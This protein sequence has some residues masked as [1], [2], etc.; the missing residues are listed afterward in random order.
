MGHLKL[1]IKGMHCRS[2]EMLLEEKI[3]EVPHVSSVN[4]SYSQGLANIEYSANQPSHKDLERAV[5][6][7]GYEVGTREPAKWLSDKWTDYKQLIVA[8]ITLWVLY[9]I[10]RMLGILDISLNTGSVTYP[11]ALVIGL[12]AGISTCMAIVGGLILGIS[13]RHAEVH[14]E[15]TSWQKFRPHL[16]FNIG[17]ISG[18]AV[19]GGLLGAMGSVLKISGTVQALL[20]LA[21][22]AV[23]IVLGLKLT[24][25]S[26]RLKESSITLPASLAKLLGINRHQKE[27]SHKSAMLT[28]ALTFFLPC[29]FTQAMQLAAIGSGNFVSGALIMG[30]FAIGTAPALLSIGGLTSVIK[31]AVAQ[32]FY[33][34]V[35]LAVFL[36][37]IYNANNALALVGF[38]GGSFNAPAVTN[39]TEVV[40]GV[41]IVRMTQKSAGYYPNSFTVKKGVPV[42]WVV[43]S[44]APYSCAASINM[45]SM[46]INQALQ[47]GE[48]VI[49]FTPT[50]SGRL[51]FSC[52]MGMY[53]GS[54]NVIDQTGSAGVINTA[55]AA[56]QPVATRGGSCGAG[57]GGCGGCGGGGARQRVVAPAVDTNA[58]DST[59]VQKIVS[60]DNRSLTPND[61]TVKVGQPV[62]WTITADA[63][64]A[65][66]MASFNNYDLGISA[67]ETYPDPTIIKFTPKSPGDYDITCPM[68]M[69]RATIH[70]K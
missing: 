57:G 15:A 41:Q 67:D 18:Y 54:F 30:L 43:T 35:G 62:E 63:P 68:G 69:Y 29:G 5:Q 31:G 25:I 40:D 26:P 38:T 70:V 61:F 46:N 10:A 6:E 16:Y 36:F 45:P 58:A 11:F 22:G 59:G 4:V 64:P 13:A 20:T 23:M 66:C 21:V 49:E 7:A 48:N 56:T 14:P 44:E 47:A 33:A 2:C 52:S 60:R 50:Q 17:R 19:L 55:Q 27:Y 9:S 3:K 8:G 42:K 51:P 24:G 12:V 34:I 1:P 53:R 28:G 39:P 65:G 37:G 32:R